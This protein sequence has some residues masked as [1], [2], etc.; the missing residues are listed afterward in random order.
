MAMAALQQQQPK[1]NKWG[2]VE[3][4]EI[5]K[6]VIANHLTVFNVDATIKDRWSPI[7]DLVKHACQTC[8]DLTYPNLKEKIGRL[9]AQRLKD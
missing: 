7:V 1:K 4:L 9:L 3:Q 6:I 8:K 5:C 2:Q